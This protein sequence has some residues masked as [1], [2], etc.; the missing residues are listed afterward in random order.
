MIGVFE[1]MGWLILGYGV[2]NA[3]PGM[4]VLGIRDS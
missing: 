1:D 3:G 2:V 4:D